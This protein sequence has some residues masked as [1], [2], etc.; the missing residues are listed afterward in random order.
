M[1]SWLTAPKKRSSKQDARPQRILPS[2]IEYEALVPQDPGDFPVS[3]L[4]CRGLLRSVAD[5]L[6]QAAVVD[7]LNGGLALAL[8]LL[9]AIMGRAYKSETDL[10]TN[11]YTV[12]LG[13]SGSGK[14]SL[15]KPAK[16]VMLQAG[17]RQWIGMDRIASAPGL[18]KMLSDFP[19]RVC[20]LDEYGRMLQQISTP[21]AGFH[22]NQ[23]I[24]EFTK[25]YSSANTLYSGTALA[26]RSEDEIECPHLCVFG[27]S[28]PQ[29]FWRAFGSAA[30]EDGSAAR[31]LILPL[32]DC[33]PRQPD[34]S[35]QAAIAE[36]L[37]K[38][39]HHVQQ[40]SHP[41]SVPYGLD[42]KDSF[43]GLRK[44][45][46]ACA[47]YAEQQEIKGASPILRR[48]AEN[49]TKIAL[50]SAVGRAPLMPEIDQQDFEIGH[51][52]ARWSA[53]IMIREIAS[54]VADNQT[55]RDVNDVES[56]IREAGSTGRSM[57]ELQRKFRRM[58]AKYL[59]DIVLSLDQ[60]E[61]V[62]QQEIKP[63]KGGRPKLHITAL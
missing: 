26:S 47:E 5:Y 62:R 27:L 60:Q 23:I 19:A 8:P 57:S 34:T 61:L 4:E 45:M 3:N 39:V 13:V 12:A 20:F 49:A 10:R 42:V 32:G 36:Q 43:S 63:L 58:S 37:K 6:D 15:V 17:A 25:L 54:H 52:V 55:E 48:V 1:T 44:T 41:V 35:G 7:S 56:F 29:Q 30:L 9:G 51:A 50:I 11:I 46:L 28:T 59:K 22:A 31:Y 40:L 14:T 2:K 24:T 21:G 53:A 16:E 18:L 38:L 33:H